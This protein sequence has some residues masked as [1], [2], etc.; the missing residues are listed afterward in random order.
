[1]EGEGLVRAIKNEEDRGRWGE[2]LGAKE[3]VRR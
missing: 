3:D 2:G 1:M